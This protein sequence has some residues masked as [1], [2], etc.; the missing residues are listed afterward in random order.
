MSK[1]IA[2]HRDT[3]SEREMDVVK[4]LYFSYG[5]IGKRLFIS[6]STVQTHIFSI[7]S[8]TR[9]HNRHELLIKLLKTGQIQLDDII[10][11]GE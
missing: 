3:L 10:Y 8:I 6:K 5:E 2:C 4:L 11:E 9:T 7:Y 1:H